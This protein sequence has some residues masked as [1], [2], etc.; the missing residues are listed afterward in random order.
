MENMFNGATA[1]NGD[2]GSWD[3]S[4]LTSMAFMFSDASGFDQDIGSWDTSNVTEMG[5]MFG[6]ASAF[7]QGIE[8]WDTSKETV[9]ENMFAGATAFNQDFWRATIRLPTFEFF[10]F[11]NYQIETVSAVL[12]SDLTPIKFCSDGEC[13]MLCEVRNDFLGDLGL[14]CWVPGHKVGFALCGEQADRC[15]LDNR[16]LPDSLPAAESDFRSFGA[17]TDCDG[18]ECLNRVR[19]WERIHDYHALPANNENT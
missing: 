1:S 3:T 18:A 10:H 2:I 11:L 14:E 13:L 16:S 12:A 4:N 15:S 6:Q 8:S 7:N 19:S 5:G 9:M 17:P